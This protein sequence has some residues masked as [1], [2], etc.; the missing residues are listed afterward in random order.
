V[1]LARLG[2]P[3]ESR[4]GLESFTGTPGKLADQ[5]ERSHRLRCRPH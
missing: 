5:R 1:S 3:R 2:I 4:S